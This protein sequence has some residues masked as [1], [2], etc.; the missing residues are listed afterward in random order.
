ME[1]W[2]YTAYITHV[3]LKAN[4]WSLGQAKVV[5]AWTMGI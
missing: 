2:Y 1:G 4:T 5:V 3:G